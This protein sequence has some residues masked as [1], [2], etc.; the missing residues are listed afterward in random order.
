MVQDFWPCVRKSWLLRVYPQ[1]H[2]SPDAMTM[3][4]GHPHPVPI[5]HFPFLLPRMSFLPP[6]FRP[7]TFSTEVW[8]QAPS[9]VIV[10]FCVHTFSL[11]ALLTFF[12][13]LLSL[14]FKSLFFLPLSSHSSVPKQPSL[15]TYSSFFKPPHHLLSIHIPW[16]KQGRKF[17]QL[18]DN[19]SNNMCIHDQTELSKKKNNTSSI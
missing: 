8:E 13:I 4:H 7:A 3:P 6:A 12:F 10:L 5:T 2:L 19:K 9:A 14:Y 18:S 1:F 16:Y 11:L 17:L 15:Q